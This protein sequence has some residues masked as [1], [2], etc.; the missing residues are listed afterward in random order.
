MGDTLLWEVGQVFGSVRAKGFDLMCL[1]CDKPV[2]CK[3]L[4]KACYLKQWKALKNGRGYKRSMAQ[5]KAVAEKYKKRMTTGKIYKVTTN[6]I[7]A[8]QASSCYL[9]G[10]VA[11]GIDHI[12][13]LSRG[14]NHSIGNL[15]PCCINCN[16]KKRTKLLVELRKY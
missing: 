15:A 3:Q 16:S 7:L 12:I 13:P 8:L 5:R 9:C 11:N 4:C 1:Q 6:E 2:H 10:I 14:G